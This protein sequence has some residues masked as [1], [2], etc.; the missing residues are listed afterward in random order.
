MADCKQ[1]VNLRGNF[2]RSNFSKTSVSGAGPADISARRGLCNPKKTKFF[3]GGRT[4]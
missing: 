4:K 1:K 2:F 3:K